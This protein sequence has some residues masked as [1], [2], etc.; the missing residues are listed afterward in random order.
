[1]SHDPFQ[2]T[3]RSLTAIRKDVERRE[4][5]SLDKDE[6]KAL[7]DTVTN[8]TVR[9][10]APALNVPGTLREVLNRNRETTVLRLAGVAGKAA[11]DVI[12]QIRDPIRAWSARL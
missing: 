5:T 11:Q 1:M 3:V 6:A 4:L 2:I 10:R 8:G 7:H 9:M 12:R